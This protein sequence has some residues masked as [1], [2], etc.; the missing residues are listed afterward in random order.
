MIEHI[1]KIEKLIASFDKA[2]INLLNKI[3]VIKHF[4][5]GDVLLNEGY[6]CKNSYH[7]TSGIARKYYLKEGKEVITDFYF[8]DDIAVA[9]N[10]YTFQQPSNEFIDCITDVEVK[11]T[12]KQDWEKAKVNFPELI[13]LDLLL[14][15]I[16]AAVLEEDMHDLRLLNATERYQKLLSI[17]PELLK[18]IKLQHIASYLN[19][20]LETLSRIRAKI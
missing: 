15:E 14:T 13:K 7:I 3:E 10:S 20:S 18:Y 12:Q 8:A 9:F 1:K 17:A 19:I 5:K 11:V 2:T 4:K 6:I 16:H